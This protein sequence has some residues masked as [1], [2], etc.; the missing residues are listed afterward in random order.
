MSSEKMI[1][2]QH[3]KIYSEEIMGL[4]GKIASRTP[5][6]RL[7]LWS[8]KWKDLRDITELDIRNW[9]FL[10][11][12]ECWYLEVIRNKAG[13]VITSKYIPAKVVCVYPKTNDLGKY[14][15]R[16]TFTDQSLKRVSQDQ[17]YHLIEI[18]PEQIKEGANIK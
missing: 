1:E 13:L 11:L 5:K 18:S 9:P 8:K 15:Y 14:H 17:I 12:E 4:A 2:K 16:I 10:L 7:E 6:D 3:R